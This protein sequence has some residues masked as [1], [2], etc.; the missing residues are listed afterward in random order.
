VTRS[1]AVPRPEEG[2]M[3]V[4]IE[5]VEDARLKGREDLLQI[6]K[7]SAEYLASRDTDP[8]SQARAVWRLWQGPN[9]ETFI[10]LGLQDEGYS[11]GVQ[12]TPNQLVPADIRELRL[13]SVWNDLLRARSHREFA[14][15]S[16]LISQAEEG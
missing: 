1:A 14:R 4:T 9:G 8:N 7:A 3:K 5:P 12:F 15:V 13:L 10:G 11:R 6:V 16:E 2:T